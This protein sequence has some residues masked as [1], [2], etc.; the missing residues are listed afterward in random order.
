MA[1]Q[2]VT[3]KSNIQTLAQDDTWY[4]VSNGYDLY[5]IMAF[6]KLPQEKNTDNIVVILYL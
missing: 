3:H 6:F 4:S 5:L 2:F 1:A